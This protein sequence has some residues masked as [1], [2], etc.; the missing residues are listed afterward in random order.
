MIIIG[1]IAANQLYREA[2]AA[3][4]RDGT[5]IDP[6]VVNY[7]FVFIGKYQADRSRWKPIT[8]AEIRLPFIKLDI[9]LCPTY[10]Q[11]IRP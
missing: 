6:V 10:I 7:P 2:L 1:I 3:S 5:G 4:H 8:I 11:Q 9:S